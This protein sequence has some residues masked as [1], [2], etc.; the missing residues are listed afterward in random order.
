LKI[1]FLTDNFPPEVNAPASRT[2]E[3][4]AEWVK[5]G[6]EVTVITCVPNFPMGKV[7]PGY[8]NKL[9]QKEMVSGIKVIRVWTFMSPNKGLMR[10]TLDF[11]SFM[12]SAFIAGLTVR[13]DLIV[14]TSP[15]F[16]TA[17]AGWMLS[18]CKMK[19]WVMEVRDLWPDSILEVEAVKSSRMLGVFFRIE[20]KMYKH[21]RLIIAVTD[22]FKKR[23]IGKG[24]REEKIRVVKN[25]ANLTLFSPRDPDPARKR[26]ICGENRWLMSYIGTH[27]MAHGLDFILDCAPDLNA[28][29]ITLL[30]VGDGAKKGE[31]EARIRQEKLTNIVMLPPAP[32]E[33]VPALLAISDFALIPLRKADLFETVIPSKIFEA[34]AMKVPIVL[35]VRGESRKLVEHYRAG[36]A[37]EPENKAELLNAVKSMISD[38]KLYEQSREGGEKLAGDFNRKQLAGELLDFLEKAATKKAAR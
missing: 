14:A 20:V 6:A 18:I 11:I 38:A 21:A 13:T 19:P 7:F 5:K 33:E 3:H 34:S 8:R 30:F 31:L 26:S 37:Y 15:Q 27:G 17:I 9:I 36:V 28:L 24:I 35:G 4:C 2:F 32:K 1:L 25:G 29:G 16:F 23:I 12:V 22:S 10:R